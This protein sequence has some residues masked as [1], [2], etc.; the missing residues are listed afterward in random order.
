[1]WSWRRKAQDTILR[2]LVPAT[3]A[4]LVMAGFVAASGLS[5]QISSAIGNEALID[6]SYCMTFNETAYYELPGSSDYLE[7]Y[8]SQQLQA[9]ATYAKQCYRANTTRAFECGTFIRNRLTST[10]QRDAAC[11]FRDSICKSNDKNVIL[12]TGL[13]DSHEDYGLNTPSSERFQH[14]RVLHCAPLKTEAFKTTY[15]ISANKSFTRYNYGA[16]LASDISSWVN[17]TLDASND[18][19]EEIR[20][21]ALVRSN[22][23]YDIV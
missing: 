14:R 13:L 17:Y 23:D 20:A 16:T 1:M 3:L 2:L 4:A 11:P 21:E 9:A 5:S 10:T 12:D 18:L 7:P 6:G 22:G 8:V 19:I 15:N